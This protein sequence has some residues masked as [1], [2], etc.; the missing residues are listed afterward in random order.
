MKPPP[1]EL[2]PNETV[3]HTAPALELRGIT[4]TS[5]RIWLTSQQLVFQPIVPWWFWIAPLVGLVFWV[6]N[7][8]HW[9]H[10]PLV[11]ISSHERTTFGRNQNVLRLVTRKGEHKLVIDALDDFMAK[12]KEAA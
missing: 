4:A 6:M 9:I 10:L 11:E 2:A 12:L 3:V 7:K 8:S 1:F 5:G